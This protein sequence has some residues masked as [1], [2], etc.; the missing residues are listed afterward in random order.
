MSDSGRTPAVR[1]S[2][3]E[4]EAA[5]GRLRDAAAEGRLTFEELADRIEAADG[6]VTREDLERLTEDLPAAPAAAPSSEAAPLPTR[7]STVFG[8]VRRAGTWTVPARGKWESLFGDVL[9]DLREARVSGPEIRIDAGTIF[10]KVEL[11][12][13]EGVEVEVRSR[14]LFGDINQEAAEAAPPGA[15]RILLT[16]GTVFG[17]VLVRS[18]RLRE[19]LAERR[20]R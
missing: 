2:D 12:V 15:P 1:A 19:R 14:T 17:D 16:G 7:T 13:P 20:R 3:A 6:A 9:L 5:M 10:G 4:R 18:K 8:D 11:L